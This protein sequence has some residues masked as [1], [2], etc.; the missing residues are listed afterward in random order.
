MKKE[1]EEKRRNKNIEWNIWKVYVY[2]MCLGMFFIIPVMVLFWQDHWLNMT[3]IMLLQSIYSL[4]V[5]VLEIPTGYISD[6]NSRRKVLAV[7]S[8]FWTLWIIGLG[9]SHMFWHF[10]LAEVCIWIAVSLSSWTVTAFIY[11]TLVELKRESEFKKIQWKV[12][13][14]WYISLAVSSIIGSI[15]ADYYNF[16]SVICLS[17]PFF[18]GSLFVALS[19]VEPERHKMVISK[20]YVAD[21]IRVI[22]VNLVENPKL[23]WIM[24]YSW[25]IIWF[26]QASL[27]L[28]QPYFKLWWLDIVYFGIVFALFQ[29][30]AA[31]SSKYAYKVE[32]LFWEKRS[33]A[34]LI[35][36]VAISYFLM[37]NF[38]FLFS[39]T[40]C[41]I[42]QFVRWFRMVVIQDAINN[43]VSSQNRATIL[44]VESFVGRLMYAF[45]I[46]VFGYTVDI[47]SLV[48]ALELLTIT[49]LISGMVMMFI[50]RKKN[51]I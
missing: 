39:F 50:L 45:I 26:N 46:P 48:Q 15:V 3:Q 41:F 25:V 14:Y 35:F 38:V 44:S 27:W 29:I 13:F 1:I 19:F 12:L 49:T 2:N 37:S 28:Y 8:L 9:M 17:V 10:A 43:V 5:V 34:A 30:V 4:V 6:A 32:E 24:I 22:K 16:F 42:H 7:S 36:L 33:L 40:F 23:R 47:F 51:I 20:N 18:I 11:D 21:L 31:F